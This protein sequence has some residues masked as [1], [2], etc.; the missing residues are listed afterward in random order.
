VFTGGI[1]ERDAAV[2]AA[3][4]NGLSWLPCPAR[5][6]PAG[7]EAQIARHTWDLLNGRIGLG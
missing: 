3:I 7:E 1:G 2:R 6:L 5:V 4:C